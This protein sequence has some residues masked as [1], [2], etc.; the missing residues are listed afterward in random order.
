MLGVGRLALFAAN[1]VAAPPSGLI[2]GG[3]AYFMG[4]FKSGATSTVREY[5]MTTG[6]SSAATNAMPSAMALGQ[7]WGSG[8][9][10]WQVGGY[11]SSDLTVVRRMAFSDET[12]T[13]LTALAAAQRN[14]RGTSSS[15]KGYSWGGYRATVNLSTNSQW[16]Y[17]TD[18]YA[19]GTA[20][21]WSTTPTSHPV[22]HT[23]NTKALF[24]GGAADG[25]GGTT[26]RHY[27]IYTFSSDTQDYSAT[28]ASYGHTL[29]GATGNNTDMVVLGGY[30][31]SSDPTS[32]TTRGVTVT[33]YTVATAAVVSDSGTIG[34]SFSHAD[35]AGNDEVGIWAGCNIDQTRSTSENAYTY[36]TDTATLLSAYLA[37]NQVF[38][39]DNHESPNAFHSLQIS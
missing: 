29:S 36:A 5:E 17:S 10:G 26:K 31:S 11:V 32:Y 3:S 39:T 8:V 1:P 16:T 25:A 33:R 38:T 12:W 21:S 23:D 19:S 7:S 30:R 22:L 15:T 9:N 18:A 6:T 28:G 24:L 37:N 14:G 13:T 34:T 35:A 20:L 4:G 27:L 2:T